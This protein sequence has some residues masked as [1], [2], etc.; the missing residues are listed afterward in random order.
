MLERQEPLPGGAIPRPAG[1]RSYSRRQDIRTG[2]GQSTEAVGWFHAQLGDYRQ[3]LI[4]CQ[5]ALDLQREIGDQF[6]E[7][8]TYDS[9][10]YAHRHLGHQKE[11]I[12]CY[13]Q[14][15]QPV[16]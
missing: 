13:Q 5:Q 12:T 2:Q 7:A 14:A 10:G 1:T 9:L 4:C 8:A 16:R 11:A 3:A 6:G 15:A